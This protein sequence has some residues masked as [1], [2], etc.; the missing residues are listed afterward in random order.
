VYDATTLYLSGVELSNAHR[1]LAYVNRARAQGA[2]VGGCEPM[3]QAAVNACWQDAGT[4]NGIDLDPAPWYVAAEPASLEFLG[5]EVTSIDGMDS[6]QAT[7]QMAPRATRGGAASRVLEGPRSLR[8]TG[9]MLATTARGMEYGQRWFASVLLTACDE[10]AG[11]DG[12]VMV[13]AACSPTT[14]AVDLRRVASGVTLE[15]ADAPRSLLDGCDA[16]FQSWSFTLGIESPDWYSAT[17]LAGF[18]NQALILGAPQACN[19]SVT[20]CNPL[21][22]LRRYQWRATSTA[23]VVG[24]DPIPTITIANGNATLYRFRIEVHPSTG[25]GAGTCVNQTPMQ[26]AFQCSTP[27]TVMEVTG[28]PPNAVLVISGSTG[29]ATAYLSGLGGAATPG[30]QYINADGTAGARGLLGICQPVCVLGAATG[31]AVPAAGSVWSV[32]SLYRFRVG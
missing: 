13:R 12:T 8:V 9:N 25:T 20:C 19:A 30:E 26:A 4:Y 1:V 16:F 22:D 23:G 7:R 14:A 31:L 10:C 28:L 11:A 29:A 18:S 5:F 24:G 32:S 3:C 21:R 17:A 6:I 15:K 2:F 27:I